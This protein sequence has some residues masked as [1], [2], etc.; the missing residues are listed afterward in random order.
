MGSYQDW[1]QS[2]LGT[3]GRSLRAIAPEALPE[4][5]PAVASPL[6]PRRCCD[7]LPPERA[8]ARIGLGKM[9]CEFAAIPA[10][11]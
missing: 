6:P 3:V 10:E 2:G 1:E 4:P 9:T 5:I 8:D 11:V 7:A